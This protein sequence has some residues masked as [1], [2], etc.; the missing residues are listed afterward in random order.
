MRSLSPTTVHSVVRTNTV[1]L[2]TAASALR[3]GALSDGVSRV[4]K[5]TT[6]ESR[7]KADQQRHLDVG[8]G[9]GGHVTPVGARK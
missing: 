8:M 9:S 4:T 6:V 5:I 2:A 1:L 3:R 7:R